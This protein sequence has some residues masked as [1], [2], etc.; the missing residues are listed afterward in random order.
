MLKKTIKYKD[1][2]GNEVEED[3]YFNL[4]KAELA[5]LEL[6]IRGGL[7]SHLRAIIA[8][9]DGKALIDTFKMILKA[10]Y[11]QRSEDGRHFLKSKEMG[12]RFI[13]SAAYPELF[14]ELITN[15]SAA[16]EFIKGI[17][18]EDMLV[19][20]KTEEVVEIPEN[21]TAAQL[22]GMTKEQLIEAMKKMSDKKN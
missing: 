8:S 6:S 20:V 12:E 17:I 7:E 21:P 14:M 1:F 2:N 15:A 3:F 18:P 5:E 22:R 11:G 4:N 9:E 19:G 16:A 10:A 13:H